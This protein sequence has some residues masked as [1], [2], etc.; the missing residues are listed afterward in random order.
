MKINT[1][2]LNYIS[3]V[4]RCLPVGLPGKTRLARYL[5]GSCLQAKDVK[6]DGLSG[7]RFMIPSLLEPIGFYLLV[8]GVYEPEVIN[9]VLNHLMSGSV[10]VDIGANIGVFTIPASKKV[11]ST[12]RVIAIEASPSIFPYLQQN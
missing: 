2:R 7:S 3:K 11:S 6:L 9:F 12:G 5:L 1:L 8:D 4:F 10:F